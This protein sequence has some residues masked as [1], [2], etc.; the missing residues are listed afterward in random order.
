[1]RPL[2]AM[3]TEEYLRKILQMRSAPHSPE[4]QLFRSQYDNSCR[5][6]ALATKTFQAGDSKRKINKSSRLSKI[7]NPKNSQG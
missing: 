6:T 7:I 1:M 4:A 5:A 3:D 2:Q